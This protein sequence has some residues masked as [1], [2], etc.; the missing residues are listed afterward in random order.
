MYH[1][2]GHL[3]ADAIQLCECNM[4]RHVY[5]AYGNLMS[6]VGQSGEQGE[7]RGV[8]RR[9]PGAPVVLLHNCLSSQRSAPGK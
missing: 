4:A 8:R 9:R 5:K 1:R 6:A 2:S 3:K 7:R